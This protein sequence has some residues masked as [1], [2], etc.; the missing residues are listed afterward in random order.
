DRPA[1]LHQ[2][3]K[4]SRVPPNVARSPRCSIRATGASATSRMVTS[5]SSNMI[6]MALF[7]ALSKG[8][9]AQ[10]HEDQSGNFRNDDGDCV[11][12]CLKARAK[13]RVIPGIHRYS[14]DALSIV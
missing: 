14:R 8:P 1:S 7:L 13:A 6:C 9:K 10:N 12:H 5:F 3:L 11:S 4:R 2:A